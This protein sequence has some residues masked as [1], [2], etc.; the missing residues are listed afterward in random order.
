M[1]LSLRFIGPLALTLAAIAYAVVPLVDRLTLQWFVRDLDIRSA[2][3]TNAIQEPLQDLVREGSRTKVLRYFD[4]II[5]DERLFGIGYC[6]DSGKMMYKT[7]TLPASIT[8]GSQG[9]TREVAGHL[10]NLER[11]LIHVGIHKVEAD[12]TAYG[13]LVLVHDMSFVQH[14]TDDTKKYIFYLFAAIAAIVSLVTVVIAEISWRGWVAG[15]KALIHGEAF[16]RGGSKVGL[17]ELRPVARDLQALINDL[18]S[19]RRAR[20]ASPSSPRR[21]SR[22]RRALHRAR[23]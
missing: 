16:V 17:P 23:Q 2:L 9:V 22:V 20:D 5:K 14:R 19:E 7:A 4:R 3:I 1:R 12:G 21:K 13:Y 8:C 10:V 15:L 6:D 18:E 11:G